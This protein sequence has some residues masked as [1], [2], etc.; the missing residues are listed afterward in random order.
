MSAKPEA[1]SSIPPPAWRREARIVGTP[2]A[3]AG[4]I[5]AAVEGGVAAFDPATGS[6]L[7]TNSEARGEPAVRSTLL[8]YGDMLQFNNGTGEVF[9]LDPA[10]GRTVHAARQVGFGTYQSDLL[11][12][13]GILYFAAGTSVYALGPGFEVLRERAL[14]GTGDL[15]ASRDGILGLAMDAETLFIE[16][17]RGMTALDKSDF[18]VRWTWD[19]GQDVYFGNGRRR[20]ALFG[21]WVILA[22]ERL[23]AQPTGRFFFLDRQSGAAGEEFAPPGGLGNFSP[24]VLG[25]TLLHGYELSLLDL[26][27]MQLRWSVDTG[28]TRREPVPDGPFVYVASRLGYIYRLEAASGAVRQEVELSWVYGGPLPDLRRP[29]EFRSGLLLDSGHFYF[30]AKDAET[31]I[32]SLYKVPAGGAA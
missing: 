9:M 30:G 7:W 8:S 4:V 13:G 11:P 23:S 12:E 16:H 22:G 17:F 19:A 1:L 6:P 10:T 26:N 28:D 5:A 24:L 3:S 14:I 32:V 27:T 25:D 31:G 2:V 29:S 18:T 15:A 21:A 20:P